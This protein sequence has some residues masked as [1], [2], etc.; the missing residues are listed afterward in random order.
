MA[1]PEADASLS[2]GL[3]G[4]FADSHKAFL[5]RV[6]GVASSASG[7]QH[8]DTFFGGQRPKSR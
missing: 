8:P 7:G 3:K 1:P 4:G 6:V 2:V 5:L